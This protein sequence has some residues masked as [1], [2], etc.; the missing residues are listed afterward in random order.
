MVENWLS[1]HKLKQVSVLDSKLDDDDDDN[2]NNNNNAVEALVR[3]TSSEIR[4][5]GC[6]QNTLQNAT[7][8]YGDNDDMM[9]E[10]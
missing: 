7:L 3:V 9:I 4:K 8:D 2:N 5:S 1:S 6:N 10:N